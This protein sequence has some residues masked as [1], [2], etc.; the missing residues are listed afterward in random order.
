[1]IETKAVEAV[2]LIMRELNGK[3]RPFSEQ[4]AEK[5]VTQHPTLQQGF[6][7]FVVRVAKHYKG[8]GWKD[9][10][11]EASKKFVEKLLEIDEPLPLI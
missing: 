2:E 6:W 9:G 7:R 10:R 3:E 4:F 5:L 1:M 11:N 8:N